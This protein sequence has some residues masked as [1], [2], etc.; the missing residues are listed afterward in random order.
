MT[1]QLTKPS[2]GLIAIDDVVDNPPFIVRRDHRIV[3]AFAKKTHALEWAEIR[4]WNDESRFA[5]HTAN[6]VINAYQDGEPEN[7]H[8]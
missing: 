8:E 6:E 7:E 4:S 5:V 1:K 2:T 3:A